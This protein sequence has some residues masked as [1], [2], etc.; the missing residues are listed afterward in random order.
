MY[1]YIFLPRLLLLLFTASSFFFLFLF[2]VFFLT[3]SRNTTYYSMLI[4]NNYKSNSLKTL[5]INNYHSLIISMLIRNLTLFLFCFFL[6]IKQFD[7]CEIHSRILY[8]TYYPHYCKYVFLF[9][10]SVFFF[11]F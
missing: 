10:V 6:L 1:S 11:F 2:L 5:L 7:I 9:F 4:R 8:Q 3:E